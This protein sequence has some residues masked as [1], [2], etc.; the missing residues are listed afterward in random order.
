MTHNLAAVAHIADGFQRNIKQPILGRTVVQ[1]NARKKRPAPNPGG[2]GQRVGP[3]GTTPEAAPAVRSV[4]NTDQSSRFNEAWQG[5]Q[6]REAIPASTPLDALHD[7][8]PVTGIGAHGTSDR[9]SQAWQHKQAAGTLSP[10]QHEDAASSAA[11]TTT[12]H[13]PVQPT[14]REVAVPTQG[15]SQKDYSKRRGTKMPTAQELFNSTQARAA[16]KPKKNIQQ[17]ASVDLSA[18]DSPSA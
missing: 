10:E 12:V 16:V 9:F 4:P 7:T 11:P 5:K 18:W 13:S 17:G 8:S 14:T 3:R 2:A 15:W 6:A 1:A